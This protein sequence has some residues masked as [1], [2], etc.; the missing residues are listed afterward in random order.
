MGMGMLFAGALSG[1]ANAVG[2]LADN[3]IKREDEAN[4]RKSMLME[5]RNELLYEMQLK[6]EMARRGELDDAQKFEGATGRA[7][8]VGDDQE[9]K[10]A[11]R[12]STAFLR[13]TDDQ[14]RR[15]P[16]ECREIRRVAR[17]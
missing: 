8:K 12:D 13:G 3:A 7:E 5:R 2:Q 17:E 15:D 16:P 11:N 4:N 1:G 10:H 9:H 6:A 14:A